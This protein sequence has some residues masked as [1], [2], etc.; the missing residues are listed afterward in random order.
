MAKAVKRLAVLQRRRGDVEEALKW[1]QQAAKDGHIYA[2]VELA[3]YYEHKV[4][5]HGLAEELTQRALSLVDEHQ[6][7]GYVRD[8]W[9]GELSHRLERIQRKLN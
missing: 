7:P 1:W 9:I 8:H 5:D 4:K 2:Y 6:L 3:K